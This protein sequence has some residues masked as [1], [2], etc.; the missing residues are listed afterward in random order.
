VGKWSHFEEIKGMKT[1]YKEH[2][3]SMTKLKLS[4]IEKR[5]LSRTIAID[6]L[7]ENPLY[8]RYLAKMEKKMKKQSF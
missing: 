4:L 2:N 5:L 8:Y 3:K 1:E 6:H 7:K